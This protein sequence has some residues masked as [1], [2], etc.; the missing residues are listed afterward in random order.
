MAGMGGSFVAVADDIN[1][2]FVNPAGLTHIDRAEYALGYTR[3]LVDSKFYSGAVAYNIDRGVVGLSVMAY[4]PPDMEE[5]TIFQPLGTG[6]KLDAGDFSIGVT[7]ARKMTD[8][9]SFGGMVRWTQETLDQDRLTSID[10]NLGT[11]FY[12]GFKSLRWGWPSR[13]WAKTRRRWRSPIWLRSMLSKR[14]R[15]C[16]QVLLSR[17]G[18][19]IHHI[20]AAVSACFIAMVAPAWYWSSSSSLCSFVFALLFG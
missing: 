3:W 1:T 7:Y 11:M 4:S 16:R 9:L 13:T 6:R 19:M 12:T 8:K 20:C 2:I 14:S 10:V 18:R 5:T 15:P 17:L